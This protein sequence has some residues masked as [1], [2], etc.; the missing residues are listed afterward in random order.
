M[1]D[2]LET[3]GNASTMRLISGLD[4]ENTTE[5]HSGQN[6]IQMQINTVDLELLILEYTR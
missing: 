4:M 5:T 6:T 2:H 1:L 3:N